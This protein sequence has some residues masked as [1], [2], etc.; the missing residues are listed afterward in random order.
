M[1][2]WF[3]DTPATR[4][5]LEEERL[6]VAATEAIS[7]AME[8]KGIKKR[9]LAEL[10]DVRPTEISQRL[11]GRR[12][13]TL[14]S[15]ASMLHALGFRAR[16]SIEDE[17]T[18]YVAGVRWNSTNTAFQRAELSSTPDFFL[19]VMNVVPQDQ[20]AMPYTGAALIP[21]GPGRDFDVRTQIGSPLRALGPGA[22][23]AGSAFQ[24]EPTIINESGESLT[25]A[26]GAA[27]Q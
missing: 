17:Q 9:Q 2:S 1:S 8:K 4:A 24:W 20:G 25:Q 6:V 22:S 23:T 12:N 16:L 13:M 14:R 10:L 7:E 11:S 18:R 21:A 5:L 3:R 26:E 15:L 27:V 19:Q